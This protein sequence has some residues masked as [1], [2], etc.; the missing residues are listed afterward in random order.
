MIKEKDWIKDLVIYQIYPRSFYDANGD[1]IGDLPGVLQKLD[2]LE[3]L[4]INAIWFSPVY[5]SPNDDNGYDISG[6]QE[7]MEEFGTMEDWERLRDA[8]KEKGI[9]IIMDL[10]VNHSSDEHPWFLE[11]RSSRDN[12]K[13]EY[14]IWRDPLDGHEPNNWASAFGGSAWE[15]VPERGQY[16]F[17]Y[18][19]KKQPDLNW[20]CPR[21]R[22]EIFHMI[23]WWVDKGV[24]GFRVDAISYLD[25]P[26]DFPDS[27]QPP[28]PDGYSFPDT[29]A[30]RPGTHAYI[31]EMNQRIYTPR[32]VL[33][34]GE[35]SA[36]TVEE[37]GNYV[38]TDRE[39]FDMAIPFVP[40][41][42]EIDTWS[43]DKLR[44]D[45][46]ESYEA[47]KGNGWW[48][49]FFS[50]H[51]KPRQV[52]LY[53]DDAQYWEVSAKLL[54]MFLHSLPGTP[55]VY[56]GEEIGMTN[57]K[58]PS[59]EDYN[60][61]DTINTYRQSL[62]SGMTPEA[63]LTRA[64]LISRDNARTPMQWDDSEQ[65]GFTTGTPWLKVNPNTAK[66]NVKAQRQDPHSVYQCYRQLIALRKKSPS[67]SR[68]DMTFLETGCKELI[69]FTRSTPGEALITF[70]NFS[71]QEL[72][73]P[74]ALLSAAGEAL[75]SSYDRE[76]GYRGPVLRPYESVIFRV[77]KPKPPQ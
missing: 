42:V 27:T 54:A 19:S 16:Y 30:G 77:K 60:D 38:R 50:N 32:N 47:L 26:R 35:V 29:L 41:V 71:G 18:F 52:S 57:V 61:L 6:Y 67:L 9:R 34:V 70:H 25:K 14:Y 33:T 7:I 22:E 3:E 37:L 5:R 62:L 31:R 74:D 36:P 45:I 65:G 21:L 20:A 15:Y 75:L 4:G 10:V 68:G 23:D 28:Q 48:A 39:E 76:G 56:Q 59:I 13:S 11:S 17:H 46:E 49:R 66:I 51:D 58:L 72:T 2:Y 64:R 69:A 73:I 63:A 40:P 8:C 24:D 43:P 44:H 1:G 12:D 53:G 55:F